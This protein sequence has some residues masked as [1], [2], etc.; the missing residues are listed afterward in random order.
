MTASIVQ[1]FSLSSGDEIRVTRSEKGFIQRSVPAGL[2]MSLSA[3]SSTGSSRNSSVYSVSPP[4]V[5]NARRG[6]GARGPWETRL[7]A[8]MDSP[9]RRPD[10]DTSRPSSG[11]PR[12]EI[13]GGVRLAGARQKRCL[14]LGRPAMSCLLFRPHT[15]DIEREYVNNVIM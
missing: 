9:T 6:K 10:Q 14:S 4:P 7:S 5:I 1:Q 13:D 8:T 11:Q 12:Q 3:R 2:F 15:I